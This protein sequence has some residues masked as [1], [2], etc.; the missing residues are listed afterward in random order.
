MQSDKLINLLDNTD[1]F[2]SPNYS[3]EKIVRQIQQQQI[4]QQRK[5]TQPIV[6]KKKVLDYSKIRENAKPEGGRAYLPALFN[7]NPGLV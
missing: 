5:R 4:S 3:T 1:Q 7:S 6:T 2:R